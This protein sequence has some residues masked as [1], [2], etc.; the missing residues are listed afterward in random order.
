MQLKDLGLEKRL[1]TFINGSEVLDYFREML[2]E[3][4]NDADYTT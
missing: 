3:L 1:V 4:P 2:I